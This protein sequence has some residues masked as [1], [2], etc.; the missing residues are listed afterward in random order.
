MSGRFVA[1]VGPSGV[2]K[3]SLIGFAREALAEDP[4][5]AFP[6]R[7]ITRPADPSEPFESV[8]ELTFRRLAAAGGFTLQW[9]AHG[10][11]YGIPAS[12]AAEIARGRTIVVNCS[13]SIIPTL[14][15]RFPA[16]FVLAVQASPD[17]IAERLARRGREEPEAQRARLE[18]AVPDIRPEDF[19]EV[20][21]ND[22][23]LEET[24]RRF[25][26]LITRV[27]ALLQGAG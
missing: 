11:S 3:D 14:R 17:V 19:D 12:A 20:L 13:R 27:P 10:L 5:F 2:G 24:G 22:G 21:M 6:R 9:Q 4:G 1:V 7:V 26:R 16:S 8:D 15:Q 23:A 18:R 25:V